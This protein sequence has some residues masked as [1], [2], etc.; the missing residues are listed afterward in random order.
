MNRRHFLIAGGC[1]CCSAMLPRV[2]QAEEPS[3]AGNWTMPPRHAKPDLAT[4]E[5]GLWD[6]ADRFE[7]QLRRNPFRIKD[8]DLQSYIQDIACQLGG[9]HCPDIRVYIMHTPWFNANMSPNGMMQVWSGL[10]LRADNEAQLAAVLGH[11]IGHYL[12]KD[13]VEG[14]RDL[15]TKSAFAQF[16]A[17]FG[18]V[19]AV[20]QLAITASAFGYSRDQERKA[21]MVG[22]QL[23]LNAGYNPA[24]ASKIWSNLL[25]E[26][27]AKPDGDPTKSS[28]LF[29]THP[30][31]EERLENLNRFAEQHPGGELKEKE[32]TEKIAPYLRGWL[33]DE[34]KRGQHEE[35]LA[36]LNRK[37][38][39]YPEN[40]EYL[41]S[42]GEVFR[43]RANTTD[44]DSALKDYQTAA[45]NKNSPPETYRGIGMIYRLRHEND[46]AN[47]YF[48]KYLQLSPDCSDSLMIKSYMEHPA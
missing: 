2:A 46:K 37:V 7:I 11:E 1:V 43:M 34:V 26:L 24:E 18:L 30:S 39:M 25:L 3:Q 19:G 38:E 27:K 13:S 29:A 42:R 22:A 16:V 48:A 33:A 23:M 40:S 20:G 6:Q 45:E 21:D 9:D 15:K 28:L 14:L 36:L 12:A 35:S 47:E 44:F 32:Y 17:P 41:F 4:D 10:L 8:K 31:T 5:G